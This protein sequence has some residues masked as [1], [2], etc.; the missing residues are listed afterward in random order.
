MEIRL[1]R[2]L[3]LPELDRFN[4]RTDSQASAVQTATPQYWGHVREVSEN[5]L[6]LF[7]NM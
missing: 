3:Q 5:P 2:L 4:E 6:N 7:E 1:V